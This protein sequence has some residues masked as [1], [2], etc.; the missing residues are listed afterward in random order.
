MINARMM[1]QAAENCFEL[2]N[3]T[4]GL[5]ARRRYM[6]MASAWQDLTELQEWL[7]GE[8]H[9]CSLLERGA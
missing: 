2:A 8:V 6:R 5:R 3:Q 9:A 1:A 7:E 4:E